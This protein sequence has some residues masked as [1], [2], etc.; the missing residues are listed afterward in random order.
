MA[1][2]S[3]RSPKEQNGQHGGEIFTGSSASDLEDEFVV[4]KIIA[5][6]V[7]D[8]SVDEEDEMYLVRWEGYPDQQCTVSIL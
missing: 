8:N 4:N 3:P 1:T 7:P 2:L 6:S 5:Q